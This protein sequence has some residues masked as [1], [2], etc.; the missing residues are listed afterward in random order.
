MY[1]L[2]ILYVVRDRASGRNGNGYEMDEMEMDIF[3]MASLVKR[4]AFS[5]QDAHYVNDM[6][7]MTDLILQREEIIDRAQ[8]AVGAATDY[9]GKIESYA[10]GLKLR[11]V[12]ISSSAPS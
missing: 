11:C 8:A 7:K 6:E 12:F 3:Q 5:H 10:A 9:V 1:N 4:V 2:S